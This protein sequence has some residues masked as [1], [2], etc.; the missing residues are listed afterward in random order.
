[1]LQ[2]KLLLLFPF[3]LFLL[4]AGVSDTKEIDLSSKGIPVTVTVPKNA[5]IEQGIKNGEVK[6]GVTYHCWE[7]VDGDFTMEV[8]MYDEPMWQSFKDYI[9]DAKMLAE[10]MAEEVDVFKYIVKDEN[11]FIC[12][13]KSYG[14]VNYEI[15]YAMQKGDRLIEFSS[16][17]NADKTSL[18]IMQRIYN[19]AKQSK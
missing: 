14:E 7:L 15:Y 12:S 2:P 4:S 17:Y 16:G 6:D 8:G 13:Y 11:G 19:A 5:A 3:L 9:R 10:L 18:A 1:M